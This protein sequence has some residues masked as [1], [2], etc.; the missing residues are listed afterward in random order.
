MRSAGMPLPPLPPFSN[1]EPHRTSGLPREE[2]PPP[3]ADIQQLLLDLLGKTVAS[4]TRSMPGLSI[5]TVAIAFAGTVDRNSD[6]ASVI[7]AAPNI[8]GSGTCPVTT[9]LQTHI[10]TPP[11][12]LVLQDDVAAGWR[13]LRLP[14]YTAFKNDIHYLTVASGLSGLRVDLCANEFFPYECG[15]LRV[16]H[17]PANPLCISCTCGGVGHLETLVSGRGSARIAPPWLRALVPPLT[18][19]K[20]HHCSRS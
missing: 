11:E 1:G 20:P 8:W 15:H 13:Y 6:G 9:A 12:I 3:P 2:T 10:A 4:L 19:F 14:A 16:I 18:R 5:S 7:A 17:E